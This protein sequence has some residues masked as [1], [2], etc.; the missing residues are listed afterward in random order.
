MTSTPN[1][2]TIQENSPKD[3]HDDTGTSNAIVVVC[4]RDDHGTIS[5]VAL[6]ILLTQADHDVGIPILSCGV[7]T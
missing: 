1:F 5:Q 2:R 3:T 4:G 6:L 7:A